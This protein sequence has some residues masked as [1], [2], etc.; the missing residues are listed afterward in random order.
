MIRLTV[1]ILIAVRKVRS[2]IGADFFLF[3]DRRNLMKKIFSTVLA[4]LILTSLTL[5][6]SSCGHIHTLSE[7]VR[8]NETDATCTS[9][10][11]YDEVI[12]CLECKQELK[13]KTK[14]TDKIAHNFVGDS[15]SVCQHKK[16]DCNEGLDL[17]LNSDG[18]SY[19]LKGIG[20]CTDTELV[21]GNYDGLPITKIDYGALEM[22]ANI[23]KITIADTVEEIGPYAFKGCSSLKSI[24]L[25]AGLAVINYEL[26]KDCTSLEKIEFPESVYEIS[27]SAFEFC[28]SLENVTL[29]TGLLSLG[30]YA[31][32]SCTSFT[33]I[34][35][36]ASLA[37]IGSYA[38][39]RCSNLSNVTMEEGVAT[40]GDFAFQECSAIENIDLPY[41]I[42]D[43]NNSAF[44][45]CVNLKSVTMQNNV[46]TIG[47]SAFYGCSSLTDVT[48]SQG[49][50]KINTSAFAMCE[51]LE[52]ITLP[53]SL[54]TVGNDLFN[55]CKKL[56]NAVIPDRVTAIGNSTFKD[57]SSLESVRF[58][59]GLKFL[60]A[61]TFDGCES[62]SSVVFAD[63]SGW[64]YTEDP[65]KAEGTA[66]PANVMN[67]PATTALYLSTNY[68]NCYL[69]K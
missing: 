7:P 55:G 13:R 29:P 46:T 53:D 69:K 6:L 41:S 68:L 65:T 25:P 63:A 67:S 16:D 12:Y 52:S 27:A 32:A 56:K 61:L 3:Y 58:G 9:K 24:K 19:M 30:S 60:G 26:F 1:D 44:L 47:P 59:T 43:I 20:T 17:S 40:V 48:L 8:E 11:S 35:I 14:S 31:F 34:T 66:I 22:C 62:L 18:E 57:C 45:N 54:I 28:S 42:S 49:L 2:P 15:C 39:A 21:I 51:S 37:Q 5:F 4:T 36:P 64:W 50:T 23:T 38:F 33:D 10:G